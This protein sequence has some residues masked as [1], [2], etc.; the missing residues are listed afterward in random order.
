M[1]PIKRLALIALFSFGTVAGFAH[2]FAHLGAH[3]AHHHEARRL[4][5]EQHVAELCVR[6]AE[7]ARSPH[8]GPRRPA[9]RVDWS[10]PVGSPSH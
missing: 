3:C 1:H 5:A 2:G 6:A 4:R 7:G 10:G 8:H 9:D